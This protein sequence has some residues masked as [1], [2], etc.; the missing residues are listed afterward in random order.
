MPHDLQHFIVEQEL[1]IKLGI[2][3]HWQQA[4]PPGRST[5]DTLSMIA[6]HQEAGG[7]S[8]NAEGLFLPRA[9]PTR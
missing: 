6:R 7:E 3:G 9:T 8:R 5:T 1:G 2:F 4:E